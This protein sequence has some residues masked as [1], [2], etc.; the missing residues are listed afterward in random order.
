MG[1]AVL[2]VRG[3]ELAADEQPPEER[4]YADVTACLLAA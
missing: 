3:F 1:V 2:S 4:G